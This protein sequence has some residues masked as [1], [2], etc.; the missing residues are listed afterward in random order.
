[1]D[2][3]EKPAKVR[4][5][6]TL[7]AHLISLPPFDEGFIFGYQ[8]DE[9]TSVFT[10]IKSATLSPSFIGEHSTI[11]ETDD[12]HLI[13]WYKCSKSRK[14][15][16]IPID[17]SITDVAIT[18][19]LQKKLKRALNFM[20]KINR[21]SSQVFESYSSDKYS[22]SSS[23][24][25]MQIP[26]D[27][28]EPFKDVCFRIENLKTFESLSLGERRSYRLYEPILSRQLN[29]KDVLSDIE[30]DTSDIIELCREAERLKKQIR[31]AENKILPIESTDFRSYHI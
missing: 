19:A 23:L 25:I 1:M 17:R 13:G 6:G 3:N 26:M 24:K 29:I 9:D 5:A 21:I 30:R 16:N 14:Q 20:I 15:D 8:A 18:H 31:D 10:S 12:S 22:L 28:Y 2:P 27:T 4:I 11:P 7:A